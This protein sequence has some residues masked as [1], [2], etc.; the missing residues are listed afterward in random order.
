MKKIVI[1]V[2]LLAVGS[3]LAIG[4]K[5][6]SANHAPANIPAI[7]AGELSASLSPQAVTKVMKHVADH[8]LETPPDVS[9][10]MSLIGDNDT[11]QW[12]YS[13]LY[14]G[15]AA[16]AEIAED[17]HYMDYLKRQGALNNWQLSENIYHA[18][19]QLVGSMYMAVAQHQDNP[20]Y[21]RALQNA[22]D[23]ILAK[24]SDI[25]SLQ[26]PETGI[27]I[28]LFEQET[29]R[30]WIWADALFMAPA[31]W[32]QLANI[33]EGDRYRQF[34]KDEFW[35]MHEMLFDEQES[36]YF[37]DSR[38]VSMQNKLGNKIFWSRGNGWV[39]AGLARILEQLSLEDN[40]R[41]K[42]EHTFI[43]VAER[44]SKI[45]RTDGYWPS[46]L[47]DN[48]E[49]QPPESSGT[50]LITFAMA[51]GINN[52]L[53]AREQYL[54]IVQRGWSALVNA[55]HRDGTLGWSQPMGDR[56]GAA[57][58]KDESLYA[59]GA[60]LL[61]GR[62]I[63]KFPLSLTQCEFDDMDGVHLQI[64][65]PSTDT[66]LT[67][68]SIELSA[69]QV[70]L[71]LLAACPR[72]HVS[73]WDKNKQK[74]LLS[75]R[76]DKDQNGEPDALLLQLNLAPGEARQLHL[77][78]QEDPSLS[79]GGIS[80]GRIVPERD[81]DFAWENNRI[82]YRVYG[83][84]L[85]SKG[86]VSSGIDVWGKRVGRNVLNDWYRNSRSLLNNYHRDRGEGADFFKV[87]ETLGIG[88]FGNLDEGALSG[89][90]NYIDAQL[91]ESG[92]LR[93]SFLLK[94]DNWLTDDPEDQITRRITLD[95]NHLLFKSVIDFPLDTPV[96]KLVT[97]LSMNNG[98]VKD[99][100]WQSDARLYTLWS[101]LEDS[102]G[103]LGAAIYLP[104]EEN[105]IEVIEHDNHAFVQ[106]SLDVHNQVT[107]YS[108]A[109]WDKSG[110][111]ESAKSWK[112]TVSGFVRSQASQVTVSISADN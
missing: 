42:F 96:N 89:P 81:D 9:I 51:W 20:E 85:A 56:P 21:Y 61:A 16:L 91:L 97:G 17:P 64:L 15:I 110:F 34:A 28:L 3:W 70:G 48:G 33:T 84:S 39:I 25:S 27:N 71:E 7:L 35:V 55:V 50:A 29:Q 93:V 47:L 86:E 105:T 90:G 54:P 10:L 103:Q 31:T 38:F 76:L 60:L 52:G 43:R 63:I 44:L 67:A 30:R 36:L 107:F 83:P 98:T 5:Q 99:E 40:D 53:L 87:G 74:S 19:A 75:Q 66:A 58:Y 59:A 77:Q 12:A 95:R 80:Y 49:L 32:L 14:L 73:V 8:S 4:I 23:H 88:G 57:S 26:H 18:D 106:L 11:N 109:C 78:L 13:T 45:Q 68:H 2:A 104:G 69:K 82:A 112:N 102:W 72:Y 92:P 111:C 62:E 1:V 108:G 79:A 100:Q 65:N 24:P 41:E 46:S 22:F 37:R 101:R 6:E 94:Y